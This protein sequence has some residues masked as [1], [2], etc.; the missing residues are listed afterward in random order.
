[1]VRRGN[2]AFKSELV[3]QCL[4]KSLKANDVQYTPL[5]NQSF[6]RG[7][8]TIDTVKLMQ[9]LT[10]AS[11][12]AILTWPLAASLHSMG[13]TCGASRYNVSIWVPLTCCGSKHFYDNCR[14]VNGTRSG[15]LSRTCLRQCR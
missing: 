6:G 2:D 4:F 9:F 14:N 11:N 13:E 15:K 8:Q 1:M 3:W 12:L 7:C 5:P 10:E